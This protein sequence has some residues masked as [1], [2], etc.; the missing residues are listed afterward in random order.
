[1]I[2]VQCYETTHPT[3]CVFPQPKYL[4]MVILSVG[5][6]YGQREMLLVFNSRAA[7]SQVGRK[8][9][10]DRQAWGL[11]TASMDLTCFSPPKDDK[12]LISS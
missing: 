4:G 1:M 11:L 9:R 8:N 5:R 12:A 10:N 3:M 7:F 2:D 6:D